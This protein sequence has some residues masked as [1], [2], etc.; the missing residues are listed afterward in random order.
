MRSYTD[1]YVDRSLIAGENLQ[2]VAI[3]GRG[4]ID[5][6]GG[7][8]RWPQY[9]TRP[10]AIRLVHCRDVLVEGV[11]MRN[12]AMWM[13]HYL[14]CD[15]VAMRGVTV[16]NHATYNNDGLDIDGCH[17]VC[18]SDC[19]F[20]SDDDAIT[21]KSTLDRACE[22]VT[23]T[24]CIAAQPLQ[25][26]QDGHRIERRLQEH[27]DRQLRDLLA[28]RLAA[29]LRLEAR[30]WPGSPWR[31]STAANWTASRSPTSP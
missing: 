12:S 31:S 17:D 28:A 22:N 13:Q 30:G 5:G 21:L 19:I 16:Y 23:I 20:D 9:L 8:F 14:A 3:R 7:K 2:N 6:N 1:N 18:V 26:D 4:T 25:R 15:R 24:N 10:Y 29:D 11:T 27:H